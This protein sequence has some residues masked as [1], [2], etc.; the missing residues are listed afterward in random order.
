MPLDLRRPRPKASDVSGLVRHYYTLPGHRAGGNLHIA[1]E[2]GNLDSAHLRFCYEQALA[3]DDNLGVQIADLLIA[4]S[5]AGRRRV[6]A[7]R[8]TAPAGREDAQERGG[9]EIESFDREVS[10]RAA[11][12]AEVF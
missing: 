11:R 12:Q 1:L 6:L 2:D 9:G 10:K 5:P 3:A 4:M 8:G 7:L